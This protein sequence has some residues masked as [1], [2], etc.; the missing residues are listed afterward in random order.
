MI[1]PAHDFAWAQVE[2]AHEIP[3][4]ALL[5]YRDRVLANVQ[6]M[7]DLAGGAQRLRPHIK[8]HKMPALTRMQLARGISKFK[9]ATIAEAEMAAAC[10]VSDML[11]AYQPVGP[12]VGRVVA[13]AASFPGTAFSVVADSPEPMRELSEAVERANAGRPGSK[14]R[15]PPL[16]VLI[17]LDVGQHRTGVPADDPKAVELYHL[18]AALPCLRPGG[19]HA[20]DGQITEPDPARRATACDEAFAPVARLRARLLDAGLPVPRIVAGGT[21]TFALHAR[22]EG[23]ECSP[24]TCVFWDAGYAAKLPDLGFLPAATL[25]TRVASKPGPGRLCLDLG[26][27][28]LASEMPHPRVQ[29]PSLPDARAV[30]HSEEHLVIETV[31]A[32][33]FRVGDCLYGVPWHICPTV[34]LHTEAIVIEQGRV[35]DRWNVAARERRLTI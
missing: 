13:L 28:A 20:Y 2:T 29:F 16:E 8:T 27:K 6:R 30:L 12:N 24:G 17:D 19:L 26:H 15:I 35:V 33:E 9:C 32:A 18:L 7:I 10:G 1:S 22:R 11:L 25:L 5:V 34:A 4:P 21:P 14:E 23:V 3:S 31:R